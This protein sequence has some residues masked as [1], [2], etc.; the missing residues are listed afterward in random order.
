MSLL[1]RPEISDPVVQAAIS[2]QR[3][4][5][6]VHIY[7]DAAYQDSTDTWTYTNVIDNFEKMKSKTMTYSVLVQVH[8]YNPE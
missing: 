8:K 1:T 2:A 7:L 6:G 3:R 4:A 5:P